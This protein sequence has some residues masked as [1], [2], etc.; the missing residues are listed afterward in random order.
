M[1]GAAKDA[2]ASKQ[3]SMERGRKAGRPGITGLRISTPIWQKVYVTVHLE[4][5]ILTEFP[6]LIPIFPQRMLPAFAKALL[7][8]S[9]GL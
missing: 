2:A 5:K 9:L 6:E 3:L 4:V 8:P 7:C 1:T